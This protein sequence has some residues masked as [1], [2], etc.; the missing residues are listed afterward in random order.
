MS[1]EVNRDLGIDDL[2]PLLTL[3]DT[4]V[5]GAHVKVTESVRENIGGVLTLSD[6]LASI[7]GAE[8]VE[9]LKQVLSL[10]ATPGNNYME[11]L[12]ALKFKIDELGGII[13][14]LSLNNDKV[15]L[16]EARAKITSLEEEKAALEVKLKEALAKLA[17][18][19]NAKTDIIALRELVLT[20]AAGFAARVEAAVAQAREA[21]EGGALT[22]YFTW[23]EIEDADRA[24]CELIQT[25][26]PGIM[27][28]IASYR[29]ALRGYEE[30]SRELGDGKKIP[31]VEL[32]KKIMSVKAAL[33][34]LLEIQEQLVADQMGEGAEIPSEWVKDDQ[35]IDFYS[36]LGVTLSSSQEEIKAAFHKLSK[37]Y[38]PDK[39]DGD[40]T[41]FKRVSSA[42]EVLGDAEIRARYNACYSKFY[43]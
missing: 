7:L 40:D 33:V 17:L 39:N 31:S 12:K 20:E 22:A 1:P 4:S 41:E 34:V 28:D 8:K 13:Q 15:E 19:G 29:K 35:L 25:L 37:K 42:W 2:E 10:L 5:K 26:K 18:L 24:C 30:I 23:K 9:T 32:F 43:Q 38:H 16:A 27:K 21:G 36:I 11:L 6:D 3:L 14:E